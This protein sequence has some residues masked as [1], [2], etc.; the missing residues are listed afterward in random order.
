MLHAASAT[1]LFA[2]LLAPASALHASPRSVSGWKAVPAQIASS[3]SSVSPAPRHTGLGGLQRV[4]QRGLSAARVAARRA[5]AARKARIQAAR[6]QAAGQTSAPAPTGGTPPGGP[7]QASGVNMFTLNANV[8][9]LPNVPP[10]FG[11]PGA[12]I[13][14]LSMAGQPLRLPVPNSAGL[15]I[16]SVSRAQ[17]GLTTDEFFLLQVPNLGL[18]NPTEVP[19]LVAFHGFSVSAADITVNTAFDTEADLRGWYLLAPMS[20]GERNLASTEG[21]RNTQAAIEFITDIYNIDE[22][23]IYGV[24][25]S[26][27]AGTALNYA[28]RYTD[29]REPRFAAIAN[30]TGLMAQEHSWTHA[31]PN[32]SSIQAYLNRYG[33][34]PTD[35]PF[36]YE[37]ASVAPIPYLVDMMGELDITIVPSV[38]ATRAFGRNLLDIPVRST[39][40]QMDPL[41]EL[42]IQNFA[43]ENF[44]TSIGAD[45]T[46]TV[47]GGVTEH[48]WNTLDA[49][50]TCNWLG[51]QSRQEPTSGDFLADADGRWFYF[52][53]FQETPGDFSQVVWDLSPA[54][55]ELSLTDTSNVDRIEVDS[56][57]L[58]LNTQAN[59]TV[60]LRPGDGPLDSDVIVIDQVGPL[61]MSVLRDGVA[62]TQWSHDAQTGEL[63]LTED[64]DSMV[65]VWTVNL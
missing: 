3:P 38:D 55:D 31:F 11:T 45:H 14:L 19:L 4:Q 8:G 7:N 15:F 37:R 27:G 59:F 29:L 30:H 12:N 26:M 50:A 41:D 49:N 20:G 43:F 57:L 33:G 24:G 32:G 61:P 9:S 2:T 46:L 42:R 13:T 40:G 54:Q 53:V 44:M 1:L 18:G 6:L 10:I 65:H 25:F 21:Q 52:D 62:T 36:E 51:A 39:L 5:F 64:D 56:A 16:L 48:N 28:C 58:G 47:V 63:T 35:V 34:S 23:R 60:R 17:F 22:D